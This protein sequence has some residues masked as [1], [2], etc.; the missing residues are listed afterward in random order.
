M[1]RREMLQSVAGLGCAA[2][3]GET[4]AAPISKTNVPSLWVTQPG[5]PGFG[6]V[7]FYEDESLSEYQ[8][9]N[10]R[11]VYQEID[12]HKDLIGGT[13]P[14][15]INSERNMITSFWYFM[16]IVIFIINY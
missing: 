6:E 3:L 7:A 9:H 11:M 15:L 5:Y 14:K 16:L 10:L 4:I 13:K 2:I 12:N 1:N 8:V